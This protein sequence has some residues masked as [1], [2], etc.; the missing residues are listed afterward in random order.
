[1]AVKSLEDLDKFLADL[2]KI[3]ADYTQALK[4]VRDLAQ[5]QTLQNFAGEHDPDGRRWDPLKE[6]TVKRKKRA[7]RKGRLGRSASAILLDSGRLFGSFMSG[8]VNEVTPT[9]LEWGTDVEY[10]YFHQNDDGVGIPRH[11]VG[12]STDAQDKIDDV[13]ADD[14]EGKVLEI[15]DGF[16]L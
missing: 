12:F 3:P 6:E 10:A 9:R 4:E 15:V 13:L 14:V 5:E 11:M 2:E 8:S 7:T 16:A 1:M